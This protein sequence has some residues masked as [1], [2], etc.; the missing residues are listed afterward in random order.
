M[1]SRLSGF[2]RLSAPAGADFIVAAADVNY[3]GLNW[4]LIAARKDSAAW[5]VDY[6]K[7]PEEKNLIDKKRASGLTEQHAVTAAIVELAHKISGLTVM[8]DGKAHYVDCM[9]FDCGFMMETVFAAV[10]SL[11]LPM[12]VFP[13]RGFAATRYHVA[14]DTRKHGNGWHFANWKQGLCFC[15][16]ADSW[17]EQ[18]QRAFLLAPGVA[19]SLALYGDSKNVH[20]RYADETCSEKLIEH[21]RTEKGDYYNWAK[22]PGVAN[23]LADAGTYALALANAAGVSSLN[24]IGAWNPVTPL[25]EAQPIATLPRADNEAQ[26]PRRLPTRRPRA[27]IEDY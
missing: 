22:T 12:R 17:R 5:C 11:R 20:R 19:G 3:S 23:D 25:P 27:P 7:H 14:R 1:L 10:Q 16:N 9:A 24:A 6:G 21:V 4:Q 2:T 18:Y 8:L 15:I 26:Q 13:V